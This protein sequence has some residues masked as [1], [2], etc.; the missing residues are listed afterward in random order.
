MKQLQAIVG[1]IS[2]TYYASTPEG[3]VRLL[4]E[5]DPVY[6]GEAVYSQNEGS[7]GNFI[8][9]TR[10]NGETVVL[11]DTSYY[12]VENNVTGNDETEKPQNLRENAQGTEET[13]RGRARDD[14]Q[15]TQQ[16]EETA[17]SFTPD[18]GERVE[19]GII[20][21]EYKPETAVPVIQEETPQ[22][23]ESAPEAPVSSVSNNAPET[24][25]SVVTGIEDTSYTFKPSDFGFTDIDGDPLQTIRI[26]TLPENGT[27]YIDGIPASAGTTV[28]ANQISSGL[29][30]F[31]SD[32]D[33]NGQNYTTFLFS[34]SDGKDFSSLPGNMTVH[35]LPVDDP[36][37]LSIDA[38]NPAVF[39]ENS[40][41]TAIADG[42]TLRDTDS[43]ITQ[44]TVKIGG[45]VSGDVLS[46]TT[47]AESGL[48]ASYDA[49][50]GTLTITGTASPAVY[51]SVLESI[52]FI[53]TSEDPTANATSV[54]RTLEW[55]VT[56]SENIETATTSDISVVPAT[57]SP[58]LAVSGAAEYKAG[59]ND[60]T[61]LS[62]ALI[63]DVDDT[64]MNGAVITITAGFT[65]GDY[66][67]AATAG[68]SITASYDAA[69]GTLTLTGTDTLE[70]YRAVLTG[71]QYGST[72][73]TPAIDSATREITWQVT[74]ANSDLAGAGIS[75]SGTSTVAIDPVPVA[76]QAADK[77]VTEADEGSPAPQAEGNLFTDGTEYEDGKDYIPENGTPVVYE[78]RYYDDLGQ[79]Q[80]TELTDTVT[81]IDTLYG[82]LTINRE[83]GDYTFKPDDVLNH[84]SGNTLTETFSYSIKDTSDG[85]VSNF[86]DQNI[87]IYD[88]TDPILNPEGTGVSEMNLPDGLIPNPAALIKSGTLGVEGGS[89]TFSVRFDSDAVDNLTSMGLTS[90]GYS[91]TYEMSSDGLAIV[92]KANG[93]EVFTVTI[94]DPAS[95]SAG[96]TFELKQPL[97]SGEDVTYTF[98]VTVT[99]SD[100]DSAGAQFDVVVTDVKPMA[101]QAADINL[102]EKSYDGASVTATGNLLTDGTGY[103]DG[104]DYVPS[105]GTAYINEIKYYDGNGD[106]QTVTLTQTVTTLNTQ[107]GELTINRETGEYSYTLT[108]PSDHTDSDTLTESFKYNIIDISDGQVSNFADQIITISDGAD[109]VFVSA[110]GVTVEETDFT[111]GLAGETNA[112]LSETGI[113]NVTG[114]SDTF[115]V[116]INDSIVSQLEALNITA[117]GKEVTYTL[118][119]D[120]HTLTATADGAEVFVLS[121]TDTNT[122]TAGYSFALKSPINYVNDLTISIPLDVADADG[123]TVSGSFDITIADDYPVANSAADVTLA[124]KSYDGTE[125]SVDGN[126][127]TDGADHASGEDFI[128]VNGT[129]QIYQVK[130]Y[131]PAGVLQTATLTQTVTTL[132]TEYG[133][134]T[135][136][137]DTGAY[138]FTADQTIDHPIGNS[139]TET[140]QY[141]F[142]DTSDGDVSN[143]AT[144]NVIITD[145]A[146]P[147]IGT[148]DA[149]TVYEASL[150][151]GSDPDAAELTQT[152]TLGVT[153]GSDTFDTVFNQSTIDY[154]NSLTLRTPSNTLIT[155]SVTNNG[156][157]LTASAG[158]ATVFTVDISDPAED[159]AA[160]SF[161][162]S[163]SIKNANDVTL[164]IPFT[165]TDSD[166][167]SVSSSINVTV[168]DDNPVA[169]AAPDT[170]VYEKSVSG[171]GNLVV[172][173]NLFTDGTTSDFIPAGGVK[174]INQVTYVNASG[175]ETT[176]T[177]AAGNNT[178]T[179][180]YGT[181]VINSTTGAYT[182]TSADNIDHTGTTDDQVAVTFSYNFKDTTDGDVS[183]TVSQTIIIKDGQVPDAGADVYVTMD[184]KYL[185]KGS[186]P[187]STMTVETGELNITRGSD[188]IT[189]KFA[190]TEADMLAL[191]LESNGVALTYTVTDT[192]ITGMA[193]SDTV[194][195]ITIVNSTGLN[196]EYKV[197]LIS[198][199]DNPPESSG[200]TDITFVLPV[201]VTDIDGDTDTNNIHITVV[202]DSAKE[203]QNITVI[204]DIA[205]T[206]TTNAD[207]NPEST[208]ASVATYGDITINTDGT[209]TYTLKPEYQHYS[210]GD[211]FTYTTVSS[212]GGSKTTTVN[213]TVTPVDDAPA[214]AGDT[215]YGAP[216]GTLIE[217]AGNITL[218]NLTLPV[219]T[220]NTDKNG[221]DAGDHPERLGY[222]TFENVPAGTVFGYVHDSVGGSVTVDSSKTVTIVIVNDD[223]SLNTD[224][225]YTGLSTS[226]AG[227]IALTEAEYQALTY[228]PAPDSAKDVTFEVHS[229][230]YEVDDSGVPLDMTGAESYDEVT[231][232]VKA[233][234]DDVSLALTD[235]GTDTATGDE[236]GWINV[237]SLFDG[238]TGDYTDGS[239]TQT[240]TISGLPAGWTFYVTT[241]DTVPADSAS[242]T[243]VGDDGEFTVTLAQGK[244]FEDYYIYV[245]PPKDYS[246]TVTGLTATLESTDH[247]SAGD[248]NAGTAVD[249][250]SAQVT[251]ISITVNPVTD[252]PTIAVRELVTSEDTAVTM[253]IR[254]IMTDSSEQALSVSIADIPEGAKIT[255][256]D[257]TVLYDGTL[258]DPTG[259]VTLVIG[260]DVTYEELK[261]IKFVPPANSNVNDIVLKITPAIQDPGADAFG[262]EYEVPVHIKGVADSLSVNAPSSY[263]G[264]ENGKVQFNAHASTA[265]TDGS[266]TISYLVEVPAGVKFVDASGNPAGSYMGNNMWAV[267]Q[268]EVDAG[269]YFEAAQDWSGVISGL[270]LV[271]TVT[272][273]DGHSL[274]TESAFDITVNP[275]VTADNSIIGSASGNEDDYITLSIGSA[276]DGSETVA[277]VSIPMASIPAGLELVVWNGSTWVTPANDGTNYIVNPSDVDGGTFSGNIALHVTDSGAFSQLNGDGVATIQNV[278][279]TVQDKYD[280]TAGGT[281]VITS[282]FTNDASVS[283]EAVAD[284]PVLSYTSGGVISG[285][286]SGPDI[287]LGVDKT[288]TDNDGSEIHYYIIS[289]VPTGVNLINATYNGD[290]TWYAEDIANVQADIT[291]AAS[292]GSY[293]LTVVGY[294]VEQSNGDTA[295]SSEMSVTMNISIGCTG[296]GE[297]AYVVEAPTLTLQKNPVA[298]DSGSVTLRTYIT[299]LSLSTPQDSSTETLSLVIKDIPAGITLES[300]DE[301]IVSLRYYTDTDGNQ[302]IR[303]IISDSNNALEAMNYVSVTLPANYSG[304]LP[305]F[306]II[307]VATETGNGYPITANTEGELVININPVAD[308]LTA[309]AN[310]TVDEDKIT[311]LSLTLGTGDDVTSADDSTEVISGVRIQI[312]YGTFVDEDGN[313]LGNN[314]SVTVDPDGTVKTLGGTIVYFLSDGQDAT[315]TVDI[316]VSGTV[317]DTSIVD[318]SVITSTPLNDSQTIHISVNP[319]P[320]PAGSSDDDPDSTSALAANDV[321]GDEDTP[322]QLDLTISFPDGDSSELQ[323]LKITGVPAGAMITDSTGTI[324]GQNNGDGSWM[325]TSI[326]AGGLFFVGSQNASGE[327]ALSVVAYA[328]EKDTM[329]IDEHSASFTVT[330]NG[331]ADGVIITPHD[332][333]GDQGDFIESSDPRGFLEG[334][335]IETESFLVSPYNGTSD[336]YNDS[337]QDELYKVVFTGVDSGMDFYYKDGSGYVH[338]TDT[339][340]SDGTYTIEKLTQEQL[341]N[342]IFVS[343]DTS[344]T[345]QLD[346]SVYSQEVN[347]DGDVISTSEDHAD[348]SIKIDVASTAVSD[349]NVESMSFAGGVLQVDLA[350]SLSGVTVHSDNASVGGTIP[351][352]IQI[353]AHA[354]E[355]ASVVVSDGDTHV[356]TIEVGSVGDDVFSFDPDNYFA[357]M[358]GEDTVKLSDSIDL[359]SAKSHMSSIEKID[360]TGNGAQSI[361]HL[362]VENVS[363]ILDGSTTLTI[364]GDTDDSVSL[365][366]GWGTASTDGDYNV[367]TANYGGVDYSIKIHN[368][369]NVG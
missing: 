106:L 135:I 248:Y 194:F 180:Q 320:D 46:C 334:A 348:G 114:G 219:I 329:Q 229:T 197:E 259:S 327:V 247:E 63:A 309:S 64:H 169:Y 174:Q 262:V 127:F 32:T 4:K 211:Q 70:N 129:G 81:V 236:D 76:N 249:P 241:S 324:V 182:F 87:V 202:D 288:Y 276:G 165:V 297:P 216:Y 325:I 346:V 367:Y 59:G 147:T 368:D 260:V 185:I 208:T 345:V 335:L 246:G 151:G 263:T 150:T 75:N 290:G 314:I 339:D 224:Y 55:T 144:Q 134:L 225:H 332:G 333:T 84:P 25:D 51:Q 80:T 357:G 10:V 27:L 49:A 250:E 205:K 226:G 101:N 255:K 47:P 16:E 237:S 138:I 110:T 48:S 117:G 240:F 296:P 152:G 79:L 69:T 210:G 213:I 354:T 40:A 198:N 82:E 115:D 304:D 98:P 105:G 254:P 350:D 201:V 365:D 271:T 2:G 170:V 363:D 6:E 45:M 177:L 359:D 166:G 252:T 53:N 107:Y 319:I 72:N 300:T 305:A 196:P 116:T 192:V 19:P 310:P 289:G 232:V 142:K 71:M 218:T 34:I 164:A 336:T 318:G 126:L 172:T 352:D 104:Q 188:E 160:Y 291:P 341:D 23:Q 301:S 273:N 199:L 175:V 337:R 179:T 93:A 58:E 13:F 206:F 136:N 57:D 353:T 307:A 242:G 361:D 261:D 278:T 190:V 44:V 209:I 295:T 256:A 97:D 37:L 77:T 100:G 343:N 186:E 122:E 35:I 223:G 272:E 3:E 221:A 89:D 230:S 257:G 95:E 90:G 31:L 91:I 8:N 204:E 281:E 362:S 222:I 275:V 207:V 358:G 74:D 130:Y 68:T 22:T 269:V 349:S 178:L 280:G 279:V 30:T 1:K 228:K 36:T 328:I 360:M 99:D 158:G 347:S 146:N 120:G 156:H 312:T 302:A 187:D 306:D 50:T 264:L 268:A 193:G 227:V 14:A 137:R 191:G 265:D 7:D 92:A 20:T 28:T 245:K 38:T 184:E 258:P 316:V 253:D 293:T 317:T 285:T 292:D 140:F 270:K 231:V 267:S 33:E 203:V 131:D 94:T 88:G 54:T 133:E 283:I 217:D 321:T 234:T 148:P 26:D 277:Q 157:T 200:D 143:F 155:Y 78:V 123:D 183:N 24:L 15:Q 56:N 132:D 369:V 65:E 141:N 39:T 102:T 62:S 73:P 42:I 173:A 67:S 364:D 159:T 344:G 145:G 244:T 153:G 356:A 313:G 41:A 214:W 266:E 119:E 12:L 239:E 215:D 111:G 9:L 161:N 243:A 154:M 220:D 108:E 113:I 17:I 103:S 195:I 52:E 303:V 5:G 326:P 167:D 366:S 311:K 83:T 60:V 189:T 112:E 351:N 323:S 124:E 322:I 286:C 162:L 139:V 118:S 149:S 29:L 11:T 287:D 171:A 331:V 168:V 299:A 298:E 163:G 238:V 330:V 212:D 18:A 43:E 340:T 66:L 338:L 96:Y 181:L 251:G 315:K 86:A 176:A 342:L 109:P 85:D 121:L 308:S 282:T 355:T 128:P 61:A 125:N 274:S 233:V 21:V 284:A 235:S 294:S